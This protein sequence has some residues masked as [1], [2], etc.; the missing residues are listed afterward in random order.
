MAVVQRALDNEIQK[1]KEEFELVE[2]FISQE[3]E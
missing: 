2:I 1:L 3:R